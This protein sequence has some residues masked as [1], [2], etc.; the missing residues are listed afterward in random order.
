MKLLRS[1]MVSE[2][3]IQ[4]L[5]SNVDEIRKLHE[6][7]FSTLYNHF[8]AYHP[9]KV[10]FADILKNILFF[11]IYIEYLNNFPSAYNQVKIL[12][13]ENPHFS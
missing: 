8:Q 12:S 6:D 2:E 11:R 7:F 10:I 1:K 3:S 9:Y 13:T 4:I 5:F